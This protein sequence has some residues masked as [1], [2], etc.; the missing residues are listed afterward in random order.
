MDESLCLYDV[1]IR[2]MNLLFVL[3]YMDIIIVIVV[4][5]LV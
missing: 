1:M 3:L 4:Y 2:S 5:S